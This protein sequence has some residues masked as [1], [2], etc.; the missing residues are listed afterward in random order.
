MIKIFA[1][2][3]INK[4]W[5]YTHSNAPVSQRDTLLTP[6]SFLVLNDDGSYTRDFGAFEYGKWTRDEMQLILTNQK[7]KSVQVP[8]TRAKPDEMQ[9]TTGRSE[10]VNFEGRQLPAEANNPFSKENNLW[11]IPATKKETDNEIRQR[12]L[13]HC[14]FWEAYFT[15][16]LKSELTSIDVRSTPTLIKIY[17]NGFALKPF[18]DLPGTWK[19]YFYDEE[20]CRKATRQIT[21]VFDR[22]NIAW[23][24]SNNKFKVFIGAFQQLQQYLK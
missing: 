6:A 9:L 3:S 10:V 16:A 2:L 13:N 5:F 1:I 7:G 12:L 4:V 20:D 8:F 19:G 17:G 15:W 14:Q 23:P 22:H 24:K 21:N 11:R 18:E